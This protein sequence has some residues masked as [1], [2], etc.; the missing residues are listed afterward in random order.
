[1]AR[2]AFPITVFYDSSGAPLANG[3]VKISLTQDAMSPT[4]QVCGS[5]S[6][7]VVLDNTGTMASV[8]QVYPCSQLNPTSVQYVVIAYTASGERASG[9]DFVTV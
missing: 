1:M 6:L 7:N 9:P 4:G 8:P 3:Y 2:V 5:C